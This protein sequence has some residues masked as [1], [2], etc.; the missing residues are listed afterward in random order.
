MLRSIKSAQRKL[1]IIALKVDATGLVLSGPD[2]KHVS[3][4]EVNE[5][6]QAGEL[7]MKVPFAGEVVVIKDNDSVASVSISD[8][9]LTIT[10][11][12]GDYSVEMLIVGSDT[13]EKY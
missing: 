2:S 8:K 10:D 12:A 7:E 3:V 13:A 5:V 11:V 1:R 9:D 6:P 4:K